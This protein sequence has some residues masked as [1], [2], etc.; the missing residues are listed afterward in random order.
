MPNLIIKENI[1]LK[2]HP[3][4]KEDKIQE[5]I[6]KNPQSLGLGGELQPIQRERKQPHGGKL[7]ILL[8]DDEGNRYEVELQ[9]GETDPSHIIRTIE[10]WDE[11]RKR[12]PQYN[13][14]AV[15]IAEKI[16]A[17]F[18]NVISLFNG[19]I[20]LIAIQM[21]AYQAGEDIQLVFTK[22]LDRIIL[23]Q[24]EEEIY[25]LTDRS[26]WEKR[27]TPKIMQL[28]DQ[29]FKRLNNL[30]SDYE[31]KYNKFYIGIAKDGT[32]NN[33]IEFKPQK[34]YL[35]FVFKGDEDLN[36]IKEIENAGFE[37]SYQPR[38]RE[39]LVK[40]Q[41]IKEYEDH[42]ALFEKMVTSSKQ[43]YYDL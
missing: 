34:H 33:F 17:R 15:I 7:D 9:L 29:I 8:S 43:Q 16:N 20:P 1:S 13:H 10:Y 35:Y 40:I 37:I 18:M 32:A 31:L 26:Y 3:L 42:Q 2:N 27:S 6:F 28:V 12:Y 38:C 24:E 11:E 19:H 22:V 23:E 21:S 4:I 5:F 39:Y 36:K 30:L 14:C 25:E 41:N